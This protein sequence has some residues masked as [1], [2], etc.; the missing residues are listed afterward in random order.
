MKDLQFHSLSNV[1]QQLSLRD[2]C[3][4]HS[5]TCSDWWFLS[6]SKYCSECSW[7]IEAVFETDSNLWNG[8]NIRDVK[9]ESVNQKMKQVQVWSQAFQRMQKT[10]LFCKSAAGTVSGRSLRVSVLKADANG[11]WN[12]IPQRYQQSGWHSVNGVCASLAK[13]SITTS[14]RVKRWCVWKLGKGGHHPAGS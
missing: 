13:T 6:E 1:F 3:L 5:A 10:N 12:P 7:K 11:A 2:I 8:I 9:R 4:R 14:V